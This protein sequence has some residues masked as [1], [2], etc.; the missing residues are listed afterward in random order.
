MRPT[1]AYRLVACAAVACTVGSALPA[2]GLEITLD[3]NTRHQ[4]VEGWG[5][6]L[7]NPDVATMTAWKNAGM[8]I[9]RMNIPKDVLVDSSGDYRVRVPLGGTLQQNVAKMNFNVSDAHQFATTAQWLKANV[10]EPDRFQLIA[11]SWS[12]PQW[13]KGPTGQSAPWVGNPSGD[14]PSFPTPWLSN[15]YNHWYNN[16]QNQ[17]NPSDNNGPTNPHFASYSGDSIGGRLKTEDPTTLSEF[18]KYMAAFVTGFEQSSGVH[19]NNISLANESTF[20]NPFDSMVMNVGPNGQTD[21]NQYA[22][23]LKS[24]R[25]AFQ[26][27]GITTTIR[28]PHMNGVG[29]SPSN[30]WRTWEQVGMING[31]KNN[32]DPTLINALS[33]YTGNYYVGYDETSVRMLAAYWHGNNN[34]SPGPGKTWAG[35]DNNPNGLANDGKQDWWVETGDGGGAWT[36]GLSSGQDPAITVALKMY[37]ALVYTDASAYIYWQFADGGTTS[38]GQ[39]GLIGTSQVTNPTA[40][41]KYDAFMQ[42]SRYIRPGAVRIDA[43]FTA[44]GQASYGGASEYDTLHGV[45]VTAYVQD[46]D[47]MLT[48]VLLNMTGGAQSLTLDIPEHLKVSLLHAFRTSSSEN[49]KQLSDLLVSNDTISFSLPG[50]SVMTLTGDFA[51]APEPASLALLVVGGAALLIRRRQPRHVAPPSRR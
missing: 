19:I 15:Q 45:N 9:M 32:S 34:V 11:D 18:G 47:R 42:F 39:Y 40:S 27:S 49:F 37:N 20:E 46:Q 21:F 16:P 24:V 33:A 17:G 5:T 6:F 10:L 23:A 29:D 26:A 30:P 44:N 14:S 4:T 28:G 8:N 1:S 3:A 38:P 51:Y 13:M 7:T 31:V 25:D 2:Q 36:T 48:L 50:Y 35:W 12:P 41:K 22:M 43:T